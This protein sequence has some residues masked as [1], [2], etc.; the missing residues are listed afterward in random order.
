MT[1]CT[2][3]PFNPKLVRTDVDIHNA[4]ALWYSDP[5]TIEKMY[6]HI[7]KWDVSLVINM[8]NLFEYRSKFNEDISR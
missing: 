6:G 4:S 2:S 5:V 7:S 1:N 3:K 8:D